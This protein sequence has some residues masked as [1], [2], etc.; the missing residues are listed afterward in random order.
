VVIFIIIWLLES[1]LVA[2]E[3]FE[4]RRWTENAWGVEEVLDECDIVISTDNIMPSDLATTI[5]DEYK[6]YVAE[7]SF[8]RNKII[9]DNKKII[10]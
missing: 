3:I 9:Y 7:K 6:K 5:L 4:K 1:L 8:L 10:H 2:G